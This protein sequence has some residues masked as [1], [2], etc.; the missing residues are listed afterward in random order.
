MAERLRRSE[1][2]PLLAGLYFSALAT[3]VWLVISRLDSGRPWT[4][5]ALIGAW[6][7]PATWAYFSLSM[8]AV[9]TVRRWWS[10]RR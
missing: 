6:L 4:E 3:P 7:F 10:R 5:L 8:L 1:R 2:H 9:R